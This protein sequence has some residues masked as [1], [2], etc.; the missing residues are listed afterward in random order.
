[1]FFDTTCPSLPTNV[2]YKITSNIKNNDNSTPVFGM[3]PYFKTCLSV[4]V[5]LLETVKS[6]S[7]KMAYT[8]S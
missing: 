1:M 3:V 8:R 2:T 6:D 4:C 7:M 5:P